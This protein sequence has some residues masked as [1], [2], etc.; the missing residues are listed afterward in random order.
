MQNDKNQKKVVSKIWNLKPFI[1]WSRFID[2]FKVETRPC[3][4]RN[5][6]MAKQKSEFTFPSSEMYM[7]LSCFVLSCQCEYV[8]N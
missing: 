2:Q 4:L 1:W 7:F 6:E 8:D 3:S 5:S